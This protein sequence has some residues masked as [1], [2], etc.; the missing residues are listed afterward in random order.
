ML[1]IQDAGRQILSG[2]PGKFYVFVGDEFGVKDRYLSILKTHYNSYVECCSVSEVFSQMGKKSLVPIP[3]K[4]YIVRYDEEYLQDLTD[5]SSA[6]IKNLNIIGT[7]VCLYQNQKHS[8]KCAKYL[9][10]YTVAFDPVNSGFIRKYLTSDFSELSSDI[11]EFAVTVRSDYKGAWNICNALR[12]ANDA[13]IMRYGEKYV[14]DTFGVQSDV[15]ESQFKLGVAAR[16]FSYT[17]SIID[18]YSG[19]IGSLLYTMLS[20]MLELERLMSNPKSKSDLRK[21]VRGWS[22]HDVY[23]MFMHIYAELERSRTISS[24]DYRG[25]LVFLISIMQFSPI[26]ETRWF[27][28]I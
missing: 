12:Y 4:L 15:S 26:P 28:E 20:T 5:K 10:D 2:N 22:L 6:T 17:N 18:S 25:G 21:Y 16:D 11:V 14:S 3:P 9:S 8:I 7:I 1:S 13:A 27:D 23:H 19:D 24:Y